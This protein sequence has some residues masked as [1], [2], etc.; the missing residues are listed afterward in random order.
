MNKSARQIASA[1]K[2]ARP[3]CEAISEAN[4]VHLGD[5]E[6]GRT[7]ARCL[8]SL[9]VLLACVCSPAV[10]VADSSGVQYENALPTATGTRPCTPSHPGATA[11]SSS[12]NGGA[13]APGQ[14]SGEGVSPSNPRQAARTSA[15]PAE[16]HSAGGP[17]S[18]ASGTDARR[19]SRHDDGGN[20]QAEDPH[21]SGQLNASTPRAS[22]SGSS[23]LAAIVIAI[24]TLA[25][26]SVGVVAARSRRE[27]KTSR[28]P[29]FPRTR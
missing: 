8:L 19:G 20:A 15:G 6:V 1:G 23:P 7:L 17:S 10:A 25:A 24:V 16:N 22:S 21:Q 13:S 2:G 11:N 29:A 18:K 28:S 3:V 27:T 9:L 26:I 4:P 5:E 12:A 14:A